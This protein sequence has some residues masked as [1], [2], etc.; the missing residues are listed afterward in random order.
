MLKKKI[1]KT[2]L[3]LSVYGGYVRKNVLPIP[4]QDCKNIFNLFFL[5]KTD[6]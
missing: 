5:T 6:N 2:V 4:F 1:L 3:Q